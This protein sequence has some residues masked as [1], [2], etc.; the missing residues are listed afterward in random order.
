HPET[1]SGHGKQATVLVNKDRPTA[2]KVPGRGGEDALGLD[3]KD[4][5]Y[6]LKLLR[7]NLPDGVL[8]TEVID[9]LR[10]QTCIADACSITTELENFS[11]QFTMTPRLGCREVKRALALKTKADVL[12]LTKLVFFE[13]SKKE[14]RGTLMDTWK[15]NSLYTGKGF[16]MKDRYQNT[17][18]S[19]PAMYSTAITRSLRSAG[20]KDKKAKVTDGVRVNV[21]DVENMDYKDESLLHKPGGNHFGMF[22]QNKTDELEC[23]KFFHE[24]GEIGPSDQVRVRYSKGNKVDFGFLSGRLDFLAH[25]QRVG[26]RKSSDVERLVIECKGTTGDMVGKLFIKSEEEGDRAQLVKTHEY[27][28]QT[29]AYMYILNQEAR[30][31]KPQ[32]VSNRAVMVIRHYHGDGAKQQDFYWNYIPKNDAIQGDISDLVIYCQR[33]VLAC[34]LAV[35]DLIFQRETTVSS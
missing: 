34:F 8:N 16:R 9:M 22:H 2:I 4:Y 23:L 30:L 18:I 10:T 31:L 35:L 32:P 17:P 11:L 3:V 14:D 28:Y 1:K 25:V 27:C 24:L 21:K 26:A 7:I 12:E 6:L 29:Q 20:H 5:L 19:T 33:E 13:T 15:K